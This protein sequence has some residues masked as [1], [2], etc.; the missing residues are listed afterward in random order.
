[1]LDQKD[2]NLHHAEENDAS[3]HIEGDKEIAVEQTTT[4]ETAAENKTE[5]T[6]GQASPDAVE[7]ND[8]EVL[9]EIDESNAED[10]ETRTMQNGI[11][12]RYWTITP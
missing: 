3:D 2:S 10:A 9:N 12:S 5:E 6:A 8:A 11:L 7:V 1:M 4:P